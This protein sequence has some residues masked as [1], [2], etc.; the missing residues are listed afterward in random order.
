MFLVYLFLGSIAGFLSG[1]LGISAGCFLVPIL[2]SALSV[3]YD[4]SIN[5]SLMV[6]II[7]S[8]ISILK[9]RSVPISLFILI[10][11]PSAIFGLI[12]DIYL[13]HFALPPLMLEFLVAVVMFLCAD[14]SR[15]AKKTTIDT[16]EED[17]SNNSLYITLSSL[18]GL[19]TSVLGISGSIFMAPFIVIKM[20]KTYKDAVKI[21][22]C[23]AMVGALAALS[24]E[25]YYEELPYAIAFYLIIGA[26]IGSFFGGLAQKYI[27]EKIL[28]SFNYWIFIFLGYSVLI[29]LL[30]NSF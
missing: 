3:P 4:V 29:R 20:N 13:R 6:L 22:G 26:T 16:T 12:G 21:A 30:Y 27:N 23:S 28:I 18:S 5:A 19:C 11:I 25:I 24:S 2:I 14:L 15:M 17:K 7:L 1:V 9:H 8:A 10:A